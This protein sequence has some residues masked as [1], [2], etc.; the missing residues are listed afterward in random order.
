MPPSEQRPSDA[1]THVFSHIPDGGG[2]GGGGGSYV[3]C[4]CPNAY[5]AAGSQA[6][7]G[8][9]LKFLRALPSTSNANS[10]QQMRIVDLVDTPTTSDDGEEPRTDF[11][12]LGINDAVCEILRRYKHAALNPPNLLSHGRSAHQTVCHRLWE[13]RFCPPTESRL[14]TVFE[15]ASG[16]E[17]VPTL[18]AEI[19]CSPTALTLVVFCSVDVYDALV[20]SAHLP[21]RC[22]TALFPNSGRARLFYNGVDA[23]QEFLPRFSPP[24]FHVLIPNGLAFLRVQS[25]ASPLRSKFALPACGLFRYFDGKPDP[26]LRVVLQIESGS[27]IAPFTETP[28][29]DLDV[30]HMFLTTRYTPS[31]THSP[32]ETFLEHYIG[33]SSDGARSTNS[34]TA[35]VLGEL[36]VADHTPRATHALARL[37]RAL[38]DF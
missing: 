11:S 25:P 19:V 5:T 16:V 30:L 38:D 35:T 9:A 8:I 3:Y 14:Y 12:D 36:V 13:G 1:M 15:V 2:D 18:H 20:A 21:S 26:N 17:H 7:A 10:L 28:S 22:Q 32:D 23:A 27:G 37:K 31:A 4:P 6:S 29:A 34:E 33:A 24:E